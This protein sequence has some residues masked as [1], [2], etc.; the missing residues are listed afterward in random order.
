M[1]FQ[2]FELNFLSVVFV[3]DE[4]CGVKTVKRKERR[5][6]NDLPIIL[7]EFI[8]VEQSF[9]VAVNF[10]LALSQI[11]FYGDCGQIFIV[12]ISIAQSAQKFFVRNRLPRIFAGFGKKFNGHGVAVG[13][14]EKFADNFFVIGRDGRN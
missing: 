7:A 10:C 4:S 9:Q 12:E 8:Q 3:C 11:F 1:T 6:A 14:A 13:F 5:V 2:I